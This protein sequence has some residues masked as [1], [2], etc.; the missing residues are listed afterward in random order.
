MPR[1]PQRQPMR[2]PSVIRWQMQAWCLT[3]LQNRLC[4]PIRPGRPEPINAMF[5]N[6][7]RLKL[8]SIVLGLAILAAGVILAWDRS[9]VSVER[10]PLALMTSL[11]IY[12]PEG[13]DI[14]A[15]VNG[16]GET[17]WVRSAL[18]KRYEITPLD[19]LTPVSDDA[20]RPL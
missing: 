5:K 6:P 2:R 18:E 4:L 19:T 11:P 7:R 17:P 8:V 13:H 12:W 16:D 14:A 3:C 9:E 10:K 1:Q 20:P 15:L